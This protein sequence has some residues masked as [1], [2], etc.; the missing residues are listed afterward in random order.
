M[1]VI[2]FDT[3]SVAECCLLMDR[4][5]CKTIEHPTSTCIPVQEA[6]GCSDVKIV[7][8]MN[9]GELENVLYFTRRRS[10]SDDIEACPT[11]C[12]FHALRCVAFRHD[13]SGYTFSQHILFKF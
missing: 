1:L 2:P 12:V 8:E 11:L 13:A 3:L 7:L 5:T 6:F 4:A 9:E 10:F